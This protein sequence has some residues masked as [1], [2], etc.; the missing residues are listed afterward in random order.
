MPV[1]RQAMFVWA[2]ARARS[3]RASFM[4]CIAMQK[5]CTASSVLALT[6]LAGGVATVA[7]GLASGL[8]G[9]DA[10]N[11]VVDFGFARFG[12]KPVV[13]FCGGRQGCCFGKN[14]IVFGRL[15]SFALEASCLS[16]RGDRLACGQS[17]LHG[18]IG[19]LGGG[20][21]FRQKLTLGS[22]R[23]LAALGKAVVVRVSQFFIYLKQNSGG[24][25]FM[26]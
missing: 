2:A 11:A 18:R 16:C 23:S 13:R 3:K 14:S 4:Q 8:V 1:A 10:G 26:Q 24:C 22:I 15:E 9:H 20:S 25:G 12:F 6:R 7:L 19:C 17:F 21:K 5:V